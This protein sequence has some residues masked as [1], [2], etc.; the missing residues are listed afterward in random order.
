MW[1]SGACVCVLSPFFFFGCVFKVWVCE[2]IGGCVRTVFAVPAWTVRVVIAW[3]IRG[4]VQGSAVVWGFACCLCGLS[5]LVLVLG[6]RGCVRVVSS[7]HGIARVL[8][9]AGYVDG[10]RWIGVLDERIA[11]HTSTTRTI[12]PGTASTVH[13][14]PPIL[15]CTHT[16]ITA[17]KKGK[18]KGH[19]HRHHYPTHRR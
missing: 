17:K 6:I 2:R 15:S 12:L 18:Q 9:C 1:D 8:C 11:H 7:V 3:R 10:E 5:V 13:T 16:P 14:A 19:T 4:W